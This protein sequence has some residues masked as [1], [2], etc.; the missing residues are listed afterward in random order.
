[1]TMKPYERLIDSISKVEFLY[2]GRGSNRY[3]SP[4]STILRRW[5][6]K[7]IPEYEF[8]YESGRGFI[9]IY[10]RKGRTIICIEIDYKT[11]KFKS[12]KKLEQIWNAIPVFVLTYEGHPNIQESIRRIP[13]PFFYLVDLYNHK[14]HSRNERQF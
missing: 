6:F 5:G 12:I 13:L 4:I 1:M 14:Y 8:R 9:D 3:I 7:V 10:A 11:V 2:G